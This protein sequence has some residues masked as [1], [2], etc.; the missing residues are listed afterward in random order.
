[1]RDV[2][3]RDVVR[4]L[5]AVAGAVVGGSPLS[6][7]AARL[8]I[9]EGRPSSHSLTAGIG[10]GGYGPL[11]DAGEELALP[12]GF[13]Y[14]VLGVEGSPM[15][16]GAVTPHAHDGMA[17]F[18]L[19]N[20]NIRLVRNHE[21]RTR[22]P[23]AVLAGSAARAYD[24]LA[25]GGT[26]SLEILVRP[27]GSPELV[28]DFVSLGGTF[29]NCAGGPTPWGSWL[30]C[31]ETT[32]GETQGFLR[33]HGYVFEVPADAEEQVTA[34]PL[35]A[36]GRFIHEAV[37]VDPRTGIV[38]LTEDHSVA[39][40]YRFIPRRQGLLSEGGWL[41]MLAIDNRPKYYTAVGQRVGERRAV[42]WVDIEDP[43]PEAA[44]TNVMALYEQGLARGGAT[45]SRLEGCF[46]GAGRLYFHATN[47]GDAGFGQVWEYRPRRGDRGELRLLFESP[48]ADV[49]NRP[50]NIVVSPRGGIVICEDNGERCY[51]RG[52]TRGGKIFDF[53]MNQRDDGEFA[54]ATFS[55]DGRTL[56]V[57]IQ[58]DTRG[59]GASPST[60]R[61]LGRTLAIWG[62]WRRGAL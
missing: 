17:A 43:D 11:G 32:E 49:L 52:L 51:L 44:E 42:H 16:D 22:P 34:V 21:D 33:D 38:Y 2:S 53:A 12:R 39:G 55:P 62:P 45:F 36:L 25:G 48:S 30:T 5:F 19:A 23:T 54:G 59:P 31:E 40:F 20:G 56:F 27:D 24:T 8:A 10:E 46:Y 26:T 1:M 7:L 61:R 3:R 28:R 14:A 57:N 29:A 13:R 50:D 41:Q 58:G 4:Q 6:G 35:P 47:G 15:S 60:T 9:A 18:R 37:A